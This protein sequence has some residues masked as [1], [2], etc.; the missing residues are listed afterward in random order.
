MKKGEKLH[1]LINR[2]F[3]GLS[4]RKFAEKAGIAPTTLQGMIE[5]GLEKASVTNVIRLARAL[6]MDAEALV[7]YIEN[8]DNDVIRE[9]REG[10]QISPRGIETNTTNYF[11][12]I[13]AGELMSIECTESA[14]QIELPKMIFGKYA[15]RKDTFI[16]KTNGESMNRVIPNRSFVMCSPVSSHHELK[17]NDIVIY[18][19][20][21]ESSMKRFRSTNKAIIF[22]PE[23]T[24]K[25]FHDVVIPFDTLEE[26]QI[27]AKVVLCLVT[28]D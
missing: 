14:E 22:S 25:D 6:G 13:S 26:V 15:D 8:E 3:P 17:D 1:L 9:S 11:G 20:N 23:S 7:T 19:I 24:D 12:P 18:S 21:N 28:L 5:R 10:H 16:M 27:H 4:N 2:K